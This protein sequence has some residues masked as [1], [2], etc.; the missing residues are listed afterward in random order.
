MSIRMGGHAAAVKIYKASDS[1]LLGEYRQNHYK[2]ENF[3]MVS[4]NDG[5]WNE[6]RTYFINLNEIASLG[7]ELYIELCDITV[8]GW[9]NAFFDD[10]ITY[11]ET[12]PTVEEG[13]PSFAGVNNYDTVRTVT[14]QDGGT[15][16]YGDVNLKWRLATKV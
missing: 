3:G 4:E 8:A 9:A 6:M 12:A 13:T 10:V 14:S 16:V 2:D 1:Q 11:Y 15:K 5:G 7:D